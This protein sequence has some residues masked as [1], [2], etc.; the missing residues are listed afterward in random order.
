MTENNSE[1]WYALWN[2]PKVQSAFHLLS[3]CWD[4]LAYCPQISKIQTYHACDFCREWCDCNLLWIPPFYDP[5]CIERSL[6]GL[7]DHEYWK[8][9]NEKD[10]TISIFPRYLSHEDES[11][12]EIIN[13]YPNIALA[14]ACIKKYEMEMLN[15]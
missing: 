6:W 5:N 12:F 9:Q 15:T 10:G 7:T 8:I 3:W 1:I 14:K 13:D 4:D 11:S 2:I